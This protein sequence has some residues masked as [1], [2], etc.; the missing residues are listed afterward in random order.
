MLPGKQGLPVEAPLGHNW[1]IFTLIVEG[2]GKD[3]SLPALTFDG[4]EPVV[5]ITNAATAMPSNAVRL[6]TALLLCSGSDSGRNQAHAVFGDRGLRLEPDR[7]L[8]SY[9]LAIW[10]P[11]HLLAHNS[12]APKGALW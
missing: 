2:G 3:A 12:T 9:G 10:G 1:Y 6:M 4:T 11:Y 7:A 5:S 8:E